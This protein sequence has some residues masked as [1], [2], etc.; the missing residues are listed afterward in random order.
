MHKAVVS[1][2]RNKPTLGIKWGDAEPIAADPSASLQ[3][4]DPS[5]ADKFSVP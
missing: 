1:Q 4:T 3:K 2:S 5:R